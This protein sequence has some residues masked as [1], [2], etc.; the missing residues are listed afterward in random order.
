MPECL[1]FIFKCA[2]D[3]YSTALRNRIRVDPVP[4]GLYLRAVIKL[5]YRFIRES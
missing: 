4:E 1:C 3:Y 2:N 5:L